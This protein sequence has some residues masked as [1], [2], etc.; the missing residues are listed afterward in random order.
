[1]ARCAVPAV[2]TLRS[3]PLV[4]GFPGPFRLSAFLISAFAFG[5]RRRNEPPQPSDSARPPQPPR[6]ARFPSRWRA[7]LLAILA[8]GALGGCAFLQPRADPTRFYVLTAPGSPPENAAGGGVRRWQVGLRSVE[9]PAYLRTRFMVVRTGT[10]ELEF[11]EFDRWAEPL[12][13]G[14]GRV[15]QAT[16]HSTGNVA[17][18]V[19]NSHGEGPL[20]FETVIR[21]QACEGV[22]LESG[23]GAIALALSWETRSLGTNATVVRFGEFKAPPAVW[24]G[25]DYGQL[26]L[27][28]SEAVAEASRAWAADLPKPT[29]VH[30]PSTLD[31]IKPSL[32]APF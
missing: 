19:L 2:P 10:N 3:T 27:R 9:V 16:L 7:F 11:A 14:I 21:I 26:A 31:M 5:V 20:D 17:S 13:Q 1:M 30:D 28:L 23:S 18:L 4:R 15:M 6:A 8:C 32:L 22:R 12:D 29:A 24:D 25:K